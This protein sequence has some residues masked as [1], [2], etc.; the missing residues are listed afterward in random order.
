M[1]T[2]FSDLSLTM[3]RVVGLCLVWFVYQ[4]MLGRH[5]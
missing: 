3:Q 1:E 4:A 2:A 5:G